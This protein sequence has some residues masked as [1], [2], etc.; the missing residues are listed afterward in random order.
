MEEVC[1]EDVGAL[2]Y[3]ECTLDDIVAPE[4]RCPGQIQVVLGMLAW[5][6]DVEDAVPTC[7]GFDTKLSELLATAFEV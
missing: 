4:F 3:T 2:Y 5:R 7:C 1:N 6:C